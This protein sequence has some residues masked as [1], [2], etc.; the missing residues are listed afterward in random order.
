MDLDCIDSKDLLNLNWQLCDIKLTYL[1]LW[2]VIYLGL[3]WCSFVKFYNFF[4][5]S[6]HTYFVVY[7]FV[8]F[9][10][11]VLI[12]IFSNFLLLIHKSATVYPSVNSLHLLFLIIYLLILFCFSMQISLFAENSFQFFIPN[13]YA[14][15]LPLSTFFIVLA[16]DSRTMELKWW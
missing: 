5:Y 11:I 16:T 1:W 9:V 6:I 2:D 14:F 3:I 4:V 12:T 7:I 10:D 15:V 8:A 13:H